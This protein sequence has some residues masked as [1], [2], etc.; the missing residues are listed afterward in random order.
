MIKAAAS[1]EERGEAVTSRAEAS[2]AHVSLNIACTWLRQC[3]T[4]VPAVEKDACVEDRNMP[5]H[6]RTPWKTPFRQ[7]P[8]PGALI[9]LMRTPHPQRAFGTIPCAHPNYLL[10]WEA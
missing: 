3:E 9:V 10:Y 6:R 7:C 5:S 8:H 4:G 1:L 2:A